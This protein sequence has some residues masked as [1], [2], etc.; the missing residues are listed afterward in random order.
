MGR[1]SGKR[2]S[3]LISLAVILG[4]KQICQRKTWIHLFTRISGQHFTPF[5][6]V[7]GVPDLRGAPAGRW[8]KA[9]GAACLPSP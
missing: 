3:W 6:W 7:P 1:S 2:R 5:G 4:N 8:L 9:G